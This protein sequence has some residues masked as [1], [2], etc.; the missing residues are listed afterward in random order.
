MTMPNH[1]AAAT[2]FDAFTHAFE[3]FLAPVSLSFI[4]LLAKDAMKLVIRHIDRVLTKPEDIE[5]RSAMAWASTQAGFCL[6]NNSGESGLHVFS[7]PLSAIFDVSHGEALSACM[8]M[9]LAQLAK[10]VPD[11]V[12]SIAAVFQQG[13]DTVGPSLKDK[14]PGAV[15][16]MEQWLKDIGLKRR[17]SDFGIKAADMDTLAKS[18]NLNRLS[19][20]W[21]RDISIS[22]VKELYQQCL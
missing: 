9:V 18:I 16:Q 10:T 6:L 4:D 15:Q 3:R 14:S 17:L 13:Q 12:A 20:A 8:P 5:A 21:G 7:L 19:S 11:K 2:G 1:V 22:E